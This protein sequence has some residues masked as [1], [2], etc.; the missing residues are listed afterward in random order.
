MSQRWKVTRNR[1]W[2]RTLRTY[3]SMEKCRIF[4]SRLSSL[5]KKRKRSHS[6]CKLSRKRS[7]QW[8]AKSQIGRNSSR[9]MSHK[10]TVFRPCLCLKSRNLSV[11]YRALSSK[12]TLDNYSSTLLCP[13]ITNKT[14]AIKVTALPDVACL[15]TAKLKNNRPTPQTT[16]SKIRTSLADLTIKFRP[17]K[18]AKNLRKIVLRSCSNW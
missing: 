14:S 18:R 8:S 16:S 4:P 3:A 12:R 5:K 2:V 15:I 1:N 6:R 17:E 13:P 10:W 9:M 11:A 7:N